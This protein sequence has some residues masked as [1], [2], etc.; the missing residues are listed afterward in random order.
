MPSTNATDGVSLYLSAMEAGD[1]F[2]LEVKIVG[3]TSD[4]G[5]NLWVCSEALESKYT[6]DSVFP[7]PNPLTICVQ[8]TPW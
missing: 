2:Y 8:G 1:N 3:I 5:V 4:G 6:N 7:P